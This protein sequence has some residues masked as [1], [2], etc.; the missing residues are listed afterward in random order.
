[1]TKGGRKLRNVRAA[2]AIKAFERLG[3]VVL[4]TKGSHY[5]LRH[6]D[7]GLLV[8]PFHRGAIKTGIMMDALKKARISIEQFEEYL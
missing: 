6:P 1:L 8:L 7:R 3:Y 2:Q 5:I 4:R